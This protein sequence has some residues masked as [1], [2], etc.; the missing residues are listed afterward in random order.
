MT[1]ACPVAS[2]SSVGCTADQPSAAAITDNTIRGATNFAVLGAASRGNTNLVLAN[3]W[4]DGGHCT[5]KLQILNGWAE[6]ASVTGNKFGP[7]R[8][9]SSC[10]FTS[11]PAVKLKIGGTQH[12]YQVAG[13][14]R[15]VD[16]Q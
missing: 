3:N 11:Y 7:N 4:L 10:A 9:V 6:T 1:R 16:A 14:S 13:I 8:A 5:V 12:E 2:S 15:F